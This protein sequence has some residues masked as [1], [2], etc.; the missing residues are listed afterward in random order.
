[1]TGRRPPDRRRAGRQPVGVPG[2]LATVPCAPT[3]LAGPSNLGRL[4]ALENLEA[5]SLHI[6]AAATDAEV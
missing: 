3:D 2:T 4:E 6:Q 1:M 5:S